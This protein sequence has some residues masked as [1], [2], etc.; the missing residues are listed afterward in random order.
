MPAFI[1]M[2]LFLEWGVFAGNPEP[3]QYGEQGLSFKFR[4]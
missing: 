4:E 2:L 3:N 1:G